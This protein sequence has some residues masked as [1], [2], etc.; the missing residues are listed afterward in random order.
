MAD[1]MKRNMFGFRKP[2]ILLMGSGI[3]RRYAKDAPCWRDLLI[4]V[5]KRCGIDDTVPFENIAERSVGKEAL[6][7]RLAADIQEDLDK[8]LAAGAVHAE[9]IF[10]GQELEWYRSRRAEAVKIIAASEC[11]RIELDPDSPYAEEIECI[12]KLPDIVPC[13]ITTNYDKVIDEGLFG[14]RF[15]VYS[16][17]PDYYLSGS[18]G[19]GEILKIHGTCDDPSSLVLTE[20]DYREFRDRGKIVSAKLLSML[21]DYPMLIIGYSIKDPDV[22]EILINLMRSLDDEKIR[23]LQRNIFCIDYDPYAEGFVPAIREIREG[24]REMAVPAFRTNDFATVFR[25]LSSMEASAPPT[26][27]RRFRQIVKN[28]Q[29]SEKSCGE[30]IRFVGLDDLSA[31]DDDKLVVVITDRENA[32]A[33]ESIPPMAVGSMVK[34]ALGLVPYN[35]DSMEMVRYFSSFGKQLYLMTEYVPIFHFM[36]RVPVEQIPRSGFIRDFIEMKRSQFDNKVSGIKLPHGCSE[37]CLQSVESMKELIEGSMPYAKPLMVMYLFDRN[38]I[39]EEQALQ[40]LASIYESCA[41]IR[42][43]TNMKCAVAYI[44]FRRFIENW[45]VEH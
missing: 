43:H 12:R 29:A 13:V 19:I 27:V 16:R 41:E 23:E 26:L 25:E 30:R 35:G 34:V 17:I 18:Q 28:V 22:T 36:N 4:R 1:T 24:G 38:M 8:R 3:S 40:W 9:D 11:S 15:K 14:N 2:P 32:K 10:T 5:A 42:G 6:F 21:C 20:S 45:K 31:D 37:E 44:G 7:P 33:F 39:S